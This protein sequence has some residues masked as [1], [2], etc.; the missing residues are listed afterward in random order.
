M[1]DRWK[2]NSI[3]MKKSRC[4]YIMFCGLIWGY[5]SG[6]IYLCLVFEV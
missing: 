5:I 4:V 3:Y 1:I 6:S 2:E